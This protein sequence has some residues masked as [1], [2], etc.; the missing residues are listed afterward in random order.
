MVAR[1]CAHAYRA[2]RRCR[3]RRRRGQVQVHHH[4]AAR[5]HKMLMVVQAGPADAPIQPDHALAHHH[6]GWGHA[7]A[8][9]GPASWWRGEDV[10]GAGGGARRGRGSRGRVG[11]SASAPGGR[12]S[13]ARALSACE[14][15][16]RRLDVRAGHASGEGEGSADRRVG[17]VGA[18]NCAQVRSAARARSA[19][20]F[21][22]GG[23][24][25]NEVR[26]SR[27]LET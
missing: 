10:R 12:R 5:H 6:A 9:G 23:D 22:G 7:C 18:G 3:G 19:A 14:A 8:R 4:L 17:G 15:A 16:V 2:A 20:I 25:A 13:R 11:A 24:M 27:R 26:G 21:A 1:G